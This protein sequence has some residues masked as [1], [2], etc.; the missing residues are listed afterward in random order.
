MA[1]AGRGGAGGGAGW[2]AGR[3]RAR[4]T[5]AHSVASSSLG[6]SHG[7]SGSSIAAAEGQPET[8]RSWA[9]SI[10]A[11]AAGGCEPCGR[12]LLPALRSVGRRFCEK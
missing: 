4:P 8:P 5:A 10:A 11:R 9:G 12:A 2:R 1:G 7:P 6:Q 3:L